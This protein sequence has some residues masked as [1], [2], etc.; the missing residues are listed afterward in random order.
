MA[1][2]TQAVQTDRLFKWMMNKARGD[3]NGQYYEENIPTVVDV[4]ASDIYAQ[5]I[6]NTPP[7]SSN[8]VIKKWYTGDVGMLT[9]TCDKKYNGNRVWVAL[10]S[11]SSSWSSGS[12][13][14]TKIMKNF[15][16]PKYGSGYVVQVYDGSGNQIS[17]LDASSWLFD[18]KAGVLTFEAD[19]TETG[20]TTASCI[21][22]QVYQYVGNMLSQA[23]AA[24][25]VR[26]IDSFTV[27]N[28]S[29]STFNLTR[30]PYGNSY[31]DIYFNGIILS[32]DSDYTLSGNVLTLNLT[33]FTN[34]LIV[35]KYY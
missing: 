34:D 11:W 28:I 21:K 5:A 2:W 3:S 19:R 18:Y 6:S 24:P 30:A 23:A 16:S 7:A 32:E 25:P 31:A 35:V 20:S 29:G 1:S 14:V 22:L 27:S 33:T 12:G 26:N 4:H 9:L 15:V 10:N 8:G 13:D 17:L